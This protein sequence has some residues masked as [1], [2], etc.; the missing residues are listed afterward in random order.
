VYQG[1]GGFIGWC[2]DRQ[3]HPVVKTT[4]D[5]VL[6]TFD[7]PARAIRCAQTVREGASRLGLDI[8]AGLHT[9]E[10]KRGSCAHL[11]DARGSSTR[12]L[13]IRPWATEPSICSG[14]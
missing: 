14:R 3:T 13:A 9:G 8:R 11:A 2:R 1:P 12:P 6:A 4:G 10:I 5:G 7:G